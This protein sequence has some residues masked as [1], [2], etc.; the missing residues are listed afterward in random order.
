MYQPHVSTL[1]PLIGPLG[2]VIYPITAR[3]PYHRRTMMWAGAVL[4]SASFFAASY[5]TKGVLYTIGGSLL[6]PRAYHTFQSSSS[7][8]EVSQMACWHCHWSLFSLCP[9][10]LF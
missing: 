6:Y 10:F 3:Y 5:I 9:R 2:P 4:C 1:L 8:D 7:P